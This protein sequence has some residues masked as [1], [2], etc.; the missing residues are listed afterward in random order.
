M[1]VC[2]CVCNHNHTNKILFGVFEVLVF[3]LHKLYKK[4]ATN[5]FY[6][7][8]VKIYTFSNHHTVCKVCD[9]KLSMSLS[10]V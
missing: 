6:Q 3:C 2:V 9:C 8:N 10:R 1:Y 5:D 7:I 4:K